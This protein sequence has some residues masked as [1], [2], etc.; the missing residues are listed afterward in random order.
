MRLLG[1]LSLAGR[2][3]AFVLDGAA[4]SAAFEIDVEQI[5][6][7]S[8]REG[9]NRGA[10]YSLDPSGTAGQASCFSP[11]AVACCF[12]PPTR[13]ISR[14]LKRRSPNSRRC[15]GEQGPAHGKPCKRP[16]PPLWISLP[17]LMRSGGLLS[18]A[19]HL[20]TQPKRFNNYQ[21]RSRERSLPPCFRAGCIDTPDSQSCHRWR[22]HIQ[23]WWSFSK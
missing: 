2:G 15:C 8:L 17:R 3:P 19:I 14:P 18:V 5:L 22:T 16:W 11:A 6:A 1:S 12:C 9:A 21:H 10:G 13:R 20:L 7:P 4:T 23:R